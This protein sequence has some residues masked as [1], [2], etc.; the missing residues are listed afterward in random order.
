MN[1]LL[2]LRVS[3]RSWQKSIALLYIIL[4]TVLMASCVTTE[5]EAMITDRSLFTG[6]LVTYDFLWPEGRDREWEEDILHFARFTLLSHPLL[7]VTPTRVYPSP[8]YSLL[9]R[10][11]LIDFTT[12][13][14]HEA[15]LKHAFLDEINKL[16]VGIPALRDAEIVLYMSS[17]AA[18]LN[19]VHTGFLLINLFQHPI[20]DEVYPFKFHAFYDGLF[21]RSAYSSYGHALYSRLLAINGVK[22]DE[23]IQRFAYIIPHESEYFVRRMTSEFIF[24][25]EMLEFIDVAD[26]IETTFTF[27]DRR[28]GVFCITTRVFRR[29]FLQDNMISYSVDRGAFL[30]HSRPERV[31]YNY[32]PEYSMIYLRVH[33]NSLGERLPQI[34]ALPIERFVIDFR[35]NPGGHWNPFI[36]QIASHLAEESERISRI[37]VLIDNYSSS[38]AVIMPALLRQYFEKVVLVG[39]NAN[40]PPNMFGGGASRRLPNS[41]LSF[42]V[43]TQL[44]RSW[45]DYLYNVLQPDIFIPMTFEDYVNLRDPVLEYIKTR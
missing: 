38:A 19:D 43:S 22:I 41:D 29:N 40:Q 18:L 35:N 32:I 20:F 9:N 25:R 15:S 30:K 8:D 14:F 26:T 11:T 6:N 23:I 34:P 33:Q 21:V 16:I 36:N 27:D 10:H 42:R 17:I 28:G 39:E 12:E 37:Y 2:R 24:I 45:P 44:T 1:K 3:M 13:D 5:V 4:V 7:R 31:W